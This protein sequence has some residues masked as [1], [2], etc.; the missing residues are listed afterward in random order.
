[1]SQCRVVVMLA[2]AAMSMGALAPNALAQ[3]NSPGTKA[4]PLVNPETGR[5]TTKA[6]AGKVDLRPRFKLGQE[7]RLKM[8][9][10]TS[11]KQTDPA[12]DPQSASQKTDIGI[13]LALK[14]TGVNPETGYTLDMVFE[15]FKFDGDIAGQTVHF[16][17]KKPDADDPFGELLGSIVGTSMP[18][19]MDLSGNISSV[20]G[21][22]T[23]LA[24]MT[25]S[26][27]GADLIKGLFG[28]LATSSKGT[29]FAAVGDTWTNEDAMDAGMGSV[30]V[31][32]TNTLSSARG[33]TATITTKGSFS[34]DPSSGG[35]GVAIRESS[36]SGETK[37]DTEAGMIDSMTMKQHVK[38]EQRAQKGAAP[39]SSTSEMD[40]KVKRVA[41]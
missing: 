18:V 26:M 10:S 32:T 20:G 33:G 5:E 37:W 38:V 12:A 14:C 4:P 28:P 39:S 22:V 21:G 30:R 9:V 2:A 25:G 24:G 35:P 27:G 15:S 11:R 13:T 6:P 41:K 29:G 19:K 23:D 31:K 36:L 40:V 34:L 16:D 3:S 8:D 7:V 1:M 17:S